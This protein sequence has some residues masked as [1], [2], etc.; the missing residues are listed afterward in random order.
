MY[1]AVEE[2]EPGN[3]EIWK[4][5]LKQSGNLR[6][7]KFGNLEMKPVLYV[8]QPTNQ[9]GNNSSGILLREFRYC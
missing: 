9:P 4:V 2:K 6:I 8:K 1:V 5:S 7:W 3:L